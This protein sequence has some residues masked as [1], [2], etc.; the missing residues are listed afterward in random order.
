MCGSN[1]KTGTVIWYRKRLEYGF[2]TAPD[3]TDEDIF[4]HR[5]DILNP[6]VNM[7]HMFGGGTLTEFYFKEGEEGPRA[8]DVTL[9]GEVA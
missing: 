3:L 1:R 6:K 2:I 7:E 5:K 9:A 8:V 4:F